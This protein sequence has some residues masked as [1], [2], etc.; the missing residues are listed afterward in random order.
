M[1][2]HLK[3]DRESLAGDSIHINGYAS[4]LHFASDGIPPC[5][6]PIEL[7]VHDAMIVRWNLDAL[8]VQRGFVG[9]VGDS[10][11]SPCGGAAKRS[12]R[13]SCPQ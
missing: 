9:F 4:G 1:L 7:D 2:T 6:F 13:A 10:R 12:R 8:L 11:V 5:A 3:R